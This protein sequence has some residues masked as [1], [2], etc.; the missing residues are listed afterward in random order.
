MGPVLYDAWIYA[1]AWLC[2]HTGLYKH[3]HPFLKTCTAHV[4]GHLRA[5]RAELT[6]AR[7]KKA[8]GDEM[9]RFPTQACALRCEKCSGGMLRCRPC[10][11]HR[12]RAARGHLRCQ[13]VSLYK[14]TTS[15]RRSS[16]RSAKNVEH[17]ARPRGCDSPR[18]HGAPVPAYARTT[19]LQLPCVASSVHAHTHTRWPEHSDSWRSAG[20]SAHY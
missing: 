17:K 20:R 3:T 14:A 12:F 19:S 9:R 10:V 4:R 15:I 5:P 6:A 1:C 7:P 11:P 13:D 16:P 18:D 8:S 2:T